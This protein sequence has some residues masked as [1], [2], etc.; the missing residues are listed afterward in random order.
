MYHHTKS[1]KLFMLLLN[2][3][4][5]CSNV[6]RKRI[7]L[8]RDSNPQMIYSFHASCT[9]GLW[10]SH[11]HD[12]WIRRRLQT[13]T[14]SEVSLLTP[15]HVPYDFL[16]FMCLHIIRLALNYKDNSST[17]ACAVH[18]PASTPAAQQEDAVVTVEQPLMTDAGV[19][20]VVQVQPSTLCMRHLQGDDQRHQFFT[21]NFATR[22]LHRVQNAAKRES[23]AI[24][25]ASSKARHRPCLHNLRP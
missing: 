5:K 16:P 22:V 3:S 9:N 19:G 14:S 25:A 23:P 11:H 4:C 7:W 8:Y 15:A 18:P 12:M 21:N 24:S 2:L 6:N 13:S 20:K 17:S 1:P 10:S